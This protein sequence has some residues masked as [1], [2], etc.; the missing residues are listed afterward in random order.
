M[1]TVEEVSPLVQQEHDPKLPPRL[2]SGP[3]VRP[4]AAA[5]RQ[6]QQRPPHRD[7]DLN[8]PPRR[9]DE[10]DEEGEREEA[11]AAGRG[12]PFPEKEKDRAELLAGGAGAGGDAAAGRPGPP[13]RGRRTAAAALRDS[14]ATL[15]HLFFAKRFRTHRVFGLCYLLQWAAALAYYCVDYEGFKDSF[16]IWSLPL[17]GIVQSITA[18]RTFTFL[19]KK[20]VDPGYFSDKITM[21]YPFIVENSFFA[22]I[23]LFQWLY[24]NDR[25]YSVIRKTVVP[26]IVFVFLRTYRLPPTF[27]RFRLRKSTA[28]RG[29]RVSRT[30]GYFLNYVR[31][32]R[33]DT[34]VQKYHIYHLLIFSAFATTVSVFL[35]TLKYIGA[36]LS[37]F[38]YSGSYFAT[39]YGFLHITDV[40]VKNLDL[41]VL[42]L[43]GLV[44]NFRHRYWQYAYQIFMLV[45][46]Y[47]VRLRRFPRC[48]EPFFAALGH[49]GGY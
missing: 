42:V 43:C 8:Q 24:Y 11:A 20:A 21:S 22:T 18:M 12:A 26:E 47:S 40:F 27:P 10:E 37:F 7:R 25:F 32:L 35:H 38:I 45:V 5:Q 34:E 23:L 9:G 1:F 33:R 2:L 17:S 30:I 14:A 13:A 44:L 3:P 16:L 4:T 29:A 15:A 49:P 28:K 48:M 31:F 39:F 19:P 6:Q 41:V 36:R 46:L